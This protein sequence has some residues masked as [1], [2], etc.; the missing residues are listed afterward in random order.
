MT[1][2]IINP[3]STKRCLAHRRSKEKGENPQV[4]KKEIHL[5]LISMACLH[6]HSCEEHDCSSDWSL[7]K[8]IDL[9]KV[10]SLS[11]HKFNHIWF[12]CFSIFYFGWFYI[13]VYGSINT[14]FSFSVRN[15]FVYIYELWPLTCLPINEIF[16]A[17]WL[18]I[19]AVLCIFNITRDQEFMQREAEDVR[20]VSLSFT[21]QCSQ[22]FSY[23]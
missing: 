14:K 9:S 6:D 4:E 16:L 13:C 21:L 17:V 15:K 5:K 3:P 11:T 22:Q 12:T 1:I 20:I 23:Y 2:H 8:H 19:L 10:T 18:R 7:Y